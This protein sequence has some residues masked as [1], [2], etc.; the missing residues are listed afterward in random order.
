MLFDLKLML[1]LFHFLVL[2]GWFC[3]QTSGHLGS[4]CTGDV[5]RRRKAA[6]L[7]STTPSG[8]GCTPSYT[9]HTIWYFLPTG[10]FTVFLALT[11]SLVFPPPPLG[12]THYVHQPAFLFAFCLAHT[13][14]QTQGTRMKS[15]GFTTHLKKNKQKKELIEGRES[16]IPKCW[17]PSL[18]IKPCFSSKTPFLLSFVGQESAG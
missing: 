15:E 12:W 9:S 16:L 4:L 11:P 7:G 14:M 8:I 5:K 10:P 6:P 3:R 1:F 2:L 17:S 13:L 18:N